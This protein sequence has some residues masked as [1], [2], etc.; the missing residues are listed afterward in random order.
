MNGGVAIH[1]PGRLDRSLLRILNRAR[2]IRIRAQDFV[3]PV[4]PL[5]EQKNRRAIAPT[6]SSIP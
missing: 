1:L 4:T 5:L 6:S 3:A 2:A